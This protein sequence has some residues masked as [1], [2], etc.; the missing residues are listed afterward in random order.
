MEI[1]VKQEK[2]KR[3]EKEEGK[4]K[5]KGAEWRGSLA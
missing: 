5:K 1:M 4:A 3:K 2:G